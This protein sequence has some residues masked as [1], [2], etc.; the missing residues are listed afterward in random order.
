L[1]ISGVDREQGLRR[2]KITVQRIQRPARFFVGLMRAPTSSPIVQAFSPHECTES[3][4]PRGRVRH[5]LPTARERPIGKSY[6]DAADCQFAGPTEIRMGFLRAGPADRQ[7]AGHP[8]PR[9]AEIAFSCD[10]DQGAGRDRNPR[11]GR[12]SAAMVH[13]R[14]PR[15]SRIRHGASDRRPRRPDGSSASTR[16]SL[17]GPRT[18]AA[19]SSGKMP[20]RHIDASQA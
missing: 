16:R 12:T 6:R 2:M 8:L 4:S 13:D 11:I 3:R 14:P 18:G 7:A 1:H 15:R 10:P 9:L 5:R 17:V 19:S 20:L